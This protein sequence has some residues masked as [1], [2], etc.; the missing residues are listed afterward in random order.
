[1]F[2]G[3]LVLD[4]NRARFA[5]PDWKC[6]LVFKVLRTRLREVLT[7]A[8]RSPGRLPSAQL[9]KWLD[10]W[11]RIFTLQQEQRLAAALNAA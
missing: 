10:V 11:Q 4:G 5:L 1:M 8:F 7:R 3:V 2:S 6:M 9:A